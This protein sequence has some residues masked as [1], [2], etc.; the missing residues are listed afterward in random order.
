MQPQPSGFR[1][2]HS[3]A[4]EVLA[5]VLAERLRVPASGADW[6]LPDTIL[7]PQFSM[8]RWL[9]QVLSEALGVCANVRFLT[10][11]EFV[12]SALDANLGAVTAGDR[13]RPEVLRWHLLRE[14]RGDPPRDYATFLGDRDGA[15]DD[16]RKAWSL[17]A[18]LADTFER[19]QAWRRD[20]LLRWEAGAD[21]ELAQ[22]QLWRRVA[23]G[24]AHR[25]RR[26]GDYLQRFG[27]HDGAVPAGLPPR[28]YVFACQNV[29]PD[30]LQVIV[31]QARAGEQEFFLHTPS[32]AFWGDLGRWGTDYLPAE[33]EA[34]AG[35]N[36]LLA[37]W[38]Q[39]GRDFIAALGS[40]EAVHAQYEAQGFAEPERTHLLGRIQADALDNCTPLVLPR[41]GDRW[42]R[43]QVDRGDPS[44][45]FHACHTPLREVQVLHDQLRALLEQP[46]RDG[47]P[48]LQPRDIAVLAPDID[49]YAPHVEAVFGDAL[50]TAREI[51]YTIAD[52]SPLASMPLA[53]AFVRLLALPLQPL[54]ATDVIALL[55]LP[56]IA[57]RFEVDD[58]QRS[59]LAYWLQ[60]AG[61]RWGLDAADRARHGAQ[62]RDARGNAAYTLQ[63]ALDRL[64][65]GLASGDDADIAGVA[66][67]PEIEGQSAQTLDA[68][69]RLLAVLREAAAR[70]DGPHPPAAWAEQLS[71]LL[72]ALV[73]AEPADPAERDTLQRLREEIAQ[74]A[75]GAATAGF[76]LPV[77]HGVVL[78]HFRAA[79]GQSDARAPFLSGGVCFGAMVPMR[80]IP[81]R[82]ICLL[83]MDEAAFPARDGR[84]PLDLINRALDSRERRVGDPSRRDADRYLF[85]QLF[86]SAGRVFY[87]SWV[88]MD[89]RDGSRREPSLP[90]AELL[91]LAARYHAGAVDTV[92]EALVV[93][94]ALQPFSPA[95]FGA[96]LPDEAAADPR[97]FSY[98]AR[99]H[100][101]AEGVAGLLPMP[102]FAAAVPIAAPEPEPRL[103]LDRL[104]SSLMRPHALYL[105]HGLGLRLPEEET[106]LS[107]HEPFGDPD[108]LSRHQLRQRV[109]D[110]WRRAGLRSDLD[111]L[112]AHLL[113]RAMLAPGADGRAL[114]EGVLEEVA[115]FVAVALR[116]GFDGAGER[117]GF[118]IALDGRPLACTL[119]DLHPQGLLRVALRP[120]GRH[121]GHAL[122]H[123]LDWLAASLQGIGLHELSADQP[124]AAPDIH[125]RPPL[126]EAAARATLSALLALRERALRSPMPFLPRSGHAWWSA[127]ARDADDAPER[128]IELASKQWCGDDIGY[129]HAEAGAATRLAL[130]GRDPFFDED[131]DAR[132]A[133]QW[134]SQRIFEAVEQ[135]T[136]F[137]PQALP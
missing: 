30:V 117:R 9:Q 129:A 120:Q 134:L 51:P 91:E 11:G 83:G 19:Y 6:L 53:E 65:L 106:P 118:E 127:A 126:P 125:Y 94:H 49:R 21:P 71:M 79:L 73:P 20:L 137:D 56:A 86:A 130:R 87:L 128:A 64:L 113:A 38:G 27:T 84:D 85:L 72:D 33:D 116:A 18:A 107:E 36:P 98:D 76:E 14:L 110:A 1:L 35:D 13:L 39:A 81:S 25:A 12:D 32:R 92:V 119:D 114:L 74:F 29:S 4:L 135:G 77:E 96:A 31:S 104:R 103:T 69:L 43:A 99:W 61:A 17:A 67:W 89:A 93:R 108:P 111:A 42:P 46:A 28:L 10:P 57:E 3:N 24:R 2:I 22:A 95:A 100:A 26:I 54:T 63:F 47:E 102:P 5:A 68:L 52:T 58:A 50:G 45:Q 44:L 136:P 59:T 122:R 34:V 82:V 62:G 15:G 16:G 40:G 7:V 55:A 41:E 8:R 112:H 48:A 23:A 133:F 109:F 37:A 90:V 132:D 80:L 66:P 124:D 105:Q 101:A 97:R 131:D 75:R 88:G 115:P 70:L 121:G 123:G 78:D 60:E